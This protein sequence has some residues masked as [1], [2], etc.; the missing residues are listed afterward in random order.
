[1]CISIIRWRPL[2]LRCPMA[3]FPAQRRERLQWQ[4]D[5]IRENQEDV[6]RILGWVACGH[7]DLAKT[8][9]DDMH[10]NDRDA[11]LQENGIL[12]STQIELLK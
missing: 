5:T 11:L 8:V 12:T 3:D 4:L 7:A 10:K 2:I 9:F 1:L 6:S